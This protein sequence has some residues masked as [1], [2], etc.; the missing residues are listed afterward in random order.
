MKHKSYL[1]ALDY[2]NRAKEKKFVG[3]VLDKFDK[4]TLVGAML[5]VNNNIYALSCHLFV[6]FEKD[7]EVFEEWLN[8]NYP[9]KHR[10]YNLFSHDLMKAIGNRSCNG[11]GL[12]DSEMLEYQ[13]PSGTNEIFLHPDRPTYDA[14]FPPVLKEMTNYSVFLSHSSV[15][16]ELVDTFFNELQKSEVE[17]W[18]DRYEISPGDSITDRINDGLDK[19]KVGL[20]FLSKSFLSGKSGWTMNEANYFFQKRMR[21]NEKNFIVVNIDLEHDE[22]PPLLQD[23]L[24][25]NYDDPECIPKIVNEL[26]KIN[27]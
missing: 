8:I 15:D 14:T 19:S 3:D 22:M 24:Y 7:S 9:D 12:L 5:Y 27:L 18:F 6:N 20:L 11:M 13:M 21:Q 10:I 2:G 4:D 16:K 17:S 26:R 25:L 23:Y 1:I